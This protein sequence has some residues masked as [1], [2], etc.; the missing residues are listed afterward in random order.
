[1]WEGIVRECLDLPKYPPHWLDR[2]AVMRLTISSPW[3]LNA[4]G[5]FNR[6]KLYSEQIKPFNFMLAAQLADLGRPPGVAPSNPIRLVT[7]FETNPQK[8]SRLQW[9]DLYSGRSYRVTTDWPGGGGSVA[10]VSSL[11]LVAAAYPFHQEPK[12][13]DRDGQPC[14]KQTDGLL[15]RRI[16]HGAGSICIGKEAH[17]LDD[18][19][20]ITHPDE[21]LNTYRDP[22]RDPWTGNVLPRL[23]AMAAKP[24]G[25]T[26]LAN[27]VGMSERRLRDVLKGRSRPRENARRVLL[28][29]ACKVMTRGNP[30]D[31]KY[32]K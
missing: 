2:A 10:G 9:T 16:V 7:P 11:D 30:M 14:V 17:R 27:T 29:E 6:S 12:R 18:R 19:S 24:G 3:H 25:M 23:R 28:A 15:R 5:A 4:L 1:L 8:W 20:L 32:S 13:I 31:F 22:R 21:L 26:G